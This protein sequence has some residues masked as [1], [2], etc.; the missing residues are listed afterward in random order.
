[1]PLALERLAFSQ[2]WCGDLV[3]AGSNAAE[4][5]RIA[6]DIGQDEVA[7]NAVVTLAIL[8]AVDGREDE[9]RA[10]VREV[11][12]LVVPR[13]LVL[14]FASSE[15]ALALLDL[16]AGR[17]ADAFAR[18]DSL[19]ERRLGKFHPVVA[20]WS[21]PDLVE[22]AMRAGNPE[23]A[24][25]A[26]A[27]FE[28]WALATRVPRVL[29]SLARCR[30]LVSEGDV[31]AAHFQEAVD[32]DLAAHPFDQARA[33]F[34]YGEYLRRERRRMHA[35]EHLRAAIEI[36]ERIGASPWADRAR[37]ELRASGETAR[38]RDPSTLSQLTPQELQIARLVGEGQS[39]K[40]VAAQLFLSPRTIDYHLRKVF[41]K[42]EI[43]SRTELVKLGIG[44]QVPA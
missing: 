30:G 10:A 18:L 37:A 40:E 3:A 6:R 8:A 31:A 39:N 35:R 11:H 5:I 4:A 25:R 16:G 27:E 21:A 44:E 13:R 28:N 14:F 34:L 7:T 26:L 12:E 42:L 38:K 9:C 20:F 32:F 36:F 29:S 43:A 2:F 22:A 24:G 23:R 19:T 17:A 41:T 33:E 15:W 1:L